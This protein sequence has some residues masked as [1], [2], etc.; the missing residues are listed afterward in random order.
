MAN[1]RISELTELAASEGDEYLEVII[2]PYTAGTNR[3]ILSSKI[4][5]SREVNRAYV[6]EMIFDKNE[7][8]VTPHE[9][10]GS[11]TFTVAAAGHLVNQSSLIT[12]V[13]TTHGTETINFSGFQYIY[14]IQNGAIPDAGTY[15]VWFVY[16][17]GR[18]TAFWAEPSL[19]V[20]SGIILPAPSNF[21]A[22][23]DG[24][25]AIDLTW[26]NVTG[27][28]G[29]FIE[30]SADGLIG[31]TTLETT[32]ADDIASTQ[33]GLTAG[34]E[35]F[36]RITTLGNGSSTLNSAYATASATTENVG[37][38]TPPTF[39][40]SP[41][42]TATD[43]GV[44]T[45]IVITA[46][47]P[48]RDTDG[49][50]VITNANAADYITLKETNGAGAD[51]A[52]TVTIDAT[53]TIFT[54]TPTSGYGGNQLVFV[55]IGGVEDLNGND[56]VA[57]NIT[58]TTSGFTTFNG[59]SNLLRFGDILDGVWALDNTKFKLRIT[60]RNI[61]VSGTRFLVAKYSPSD[62][63]LS[64][65]WWTSGASVM[66]T[67]C[68]VGTSSSR[69]IRWENVLDASEHDLE[70]Q[71]DGAIDTNDGLDRATL[72][73]DA[74]TAGSKTLLSS[75]GILSGIIF[76]SS[77]QLAFG[78]GVNSAGTVTSANYFAGDAK[79]LQILSGAGDVNEL[80]VP[81]LAE[82]TDTSGNARHGTWV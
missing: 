81:V 71:Y 22:V 63:Q 31:W 74:V 24:E 3:K 77:A 36:Y 30:W 48:V 75:T 46:S 50:T 47:E 67:W 28:Q 18:T 72:L 14:G 58:F 35:R 76:A 15:Q 4:G 17:N 10:T 32:P 41:T 66:F 53:K 70:L 62:N 25:T 82:G 40:F 26:T 37:D 73:I 64:F 55:E 65:V 52:K 51:I 6:E 43:V 16:M 68:R 45:P 11:P 19:Q 44:S 9:L 56:A 8:D 49:V 59:T 57:D 69:V 12:Y 21:V 39:T 79:D 42:D 7:I 80:Q 60:V 61:P 27:N 20:A 38:V 23:A 29:Y 34:T 1:Q 2:P 54:I 78:A 5:Y 33:T 13:I